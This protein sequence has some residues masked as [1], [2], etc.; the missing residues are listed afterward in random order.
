MKQNKE[1]LCCVDIYS[2]GANNTSSFNCVKQNYNNHN[3]KNSVDDFYI[4][5]VRFECTRNAGIPMYGETQE[6]LQKRKKARCVHHRLRIV[7]AVPLV[8]VP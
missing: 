2:R 5:D 3:N 4:N 6:R 8:N 1:T 7:F